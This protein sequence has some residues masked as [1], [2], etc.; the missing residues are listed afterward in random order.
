MISLKPPLNFSPKLEVVSCHIEHGSLLLVLQ[1]QHH[2]PQGGTWGVPAGK[3][4]RGEDLVNALYREVHE[5]TGVDINQVSVH[6]VS[7]CYVQYE[8]YDF[9]YHIYQ[10]ILTER[11][12]VVI[13]TKEHIAYKWV[14]PKEA[15]RLPL[16]QDED[17]CI[18]LLYGL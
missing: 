17:Y 13:N 8:T 12:T 1:R 2:K 11:P 7:T 18:R 3:V 16:I 14:T 10:A 15:L 5:E 6:F 9:V 4:D